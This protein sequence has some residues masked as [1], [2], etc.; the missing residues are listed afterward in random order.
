V[1]LLCEQGPGKG[2]EDVQKG[3]IE[4]RSLNKK[5]GVPPATKKGTFTQIK[6]M[7]GGSKKKDGR[8]GK[9]QVSQLKKKKNPGDT[10][11][12]LREKKETKTTTKG[13]CGQRRKKVPK[14]DNLAHTKRKFL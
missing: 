9:I 7:F 8:M 2:P 12:A 3:G 13:D 4:M 11:R 14:L 5:G 6:R 1:K 10:N